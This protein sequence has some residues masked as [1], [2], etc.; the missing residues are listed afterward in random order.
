MR[1]A[2]EVAQGTYKKSSSVEPLMI[3]EYRVAE[4]LADTLSEKVTLLQICLNKLFH[5]LQ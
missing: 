3:L 1:I 4:E 2:Q 5:N